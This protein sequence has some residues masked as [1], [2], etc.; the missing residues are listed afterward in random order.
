MNDNCAPLDPGTR[1]EI[2]QAAGYERLAAVLA[3]AFEQASVGKGKE[4]HA[5]ALPFDQQPMQT[6][7]RDHGIGF[8][9]GQARK[10]AEE[11]LGM[12]AR[13][14]REAAVKELLGAIVYTAGAVIFIQD[15]SQE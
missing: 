4:R 8:I 5:N 6:I 10:K 15:Q 1:R 12:L 3:S 9:T 14:E 13:G 2:L 7:A 11:A